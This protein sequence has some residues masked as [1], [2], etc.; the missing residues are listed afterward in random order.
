LNTKEDILKNVR[1]QTVNFLFTMGFLF[2]IHQLF[3]FRH[4][5]E[6]LLLCSTEETQTGLKQHDNNW[7]YFW[8]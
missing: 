2:T 5:P 1:N 3:G 8:V 4:S 7:L 6:Y